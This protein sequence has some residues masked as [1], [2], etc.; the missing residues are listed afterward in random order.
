MKISNVTN[1]IPCSAHGSV[2]HELLTGGE[3]Q[4]VTIKSFPIDHWIVACNDCC[5]FF[6]SPCNHARNSNFVGSDRDTKL[7]VQV[8]V[9]IDTI[10]RTASSVRTIE[11]VP[12]NCG[13]FKSHGAVSNTIV[14]QVI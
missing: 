6:G 2:S 1:T 8:P 12:P 5:A 9:I 7:P 13:M 10:W 3:R 11:G 4:F 14:I